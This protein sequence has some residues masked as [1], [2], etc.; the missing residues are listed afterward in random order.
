RIIG[1]AH[2]ALVTA[3][4]PKAME[5]AFG[6]LRARGTMA[7]VGLPP[8]DISLPVFNTVLK[9][10]TVRGSI[11]GTRQ[12]LEESLVFAAEGKV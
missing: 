9:R 1:G 3:V 2:G 10:I 4:S 11:V 12:D 8:G 5:Q 7:L 6:F